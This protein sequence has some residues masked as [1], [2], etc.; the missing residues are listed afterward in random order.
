MDDLPSGRGSAAES[1]RRHGGSTRSWYWEGNFAGL[2]AAL[3]VQHELRGDVNVTV[4][5]A[6]NQ[7]LINPSLIS[8]PFGNRAPDEITFTLAPTFDAQ[9]INFSHTSATEIDLPAS[10]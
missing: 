10:G 1:E 3:T 9:G 7:F 6:N 5:S 2:T 8:L 4:L